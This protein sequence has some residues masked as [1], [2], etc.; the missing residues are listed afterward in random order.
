MKHRKHHSEIQETQA[1]NL[2]DPWLKYKKVCYYKEIFTF[3]TIFIFILFFT[4]VQSSIFTSQRWK[5]NQN[6]NQKL[7]RCQ[8]FQWENLSSISSMN[9]LSNKYF[10]IVLKSEFDLITSWKY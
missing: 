10:E 5:W 6:Q 7:E 9:F 1:E 2:Y 8:D 3:Q 4:L